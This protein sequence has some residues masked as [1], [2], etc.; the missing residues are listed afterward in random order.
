MNFIKLLSTEWQ[1]FIVF[2]LTMN[3]FEALMTWNSIV[4]LLQSLLQRA[5]ENRQIKSCLAFC[6]NVW[7]LLNKFLAG[8]AKNGVGDRGRLIWSASAGDLVPS[9]NMKYQSWAWSSDTQL[10]T[11]SLL[12]CWPLEPWSSF[13]GQVFQV[14]LRDSSGIL[15][16]VLV[17]RNSPLLYTRGFTQQTPSD[18]PGI[19]KPPSRGSGSRTGNSSPVYWRCSTLWKRTSRNKREEGREKAENAF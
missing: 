7:L 12:C 11:G 13:L 3:G 6:S 17:T 2:L 5:T 1:L 8:L 15:K 16:D 10:R 9:E 19:L 4:I 18:S 14:F